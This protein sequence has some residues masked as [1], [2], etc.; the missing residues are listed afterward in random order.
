MPPLNASVPNTALPGEARRLGFSIGLKHWISDPPVA[1]PISAQVFDEAGVTI[2]RVGE[3]IAAIIHESMVS[4]LLECMDAHEGTVGMSE[5]MQ[6]VTRMFAMTMARVCKQTNCVEWAPQVRFVLV[7]RDP[8]DAAVSYAHWMRIFDPAKDLQQTMR[9]AWIFVP[10]TM[11]MFEWYANTLSYFFPTLVV[12]Y[13]ELVNNLP[14][15][16]ARLQEFLGLPPLSPADIA[17][18]EVAVSPDHMRELELQ[19]ALPGRNSQ[20]RPKVRKARPETFREE[21]EPETV[22]I[23][24]KAMRKYLTPE[25]LNRFPA[26]EDD[27]T[28]SLA[29]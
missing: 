29:S 6:D 17:A 16:L 19:H 4:R 11:Q 23:F 2:P 3:D 25:L 13:S 14:T 24:N 27:A 22:T 26:T 1:D 12:Y 18:M 21:M 28:Y 5:C 10:R 15:E 8:R 7:V 20:Q 9:E